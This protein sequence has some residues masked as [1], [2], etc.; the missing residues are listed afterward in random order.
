MILQKFD[1]IRFSLSTQIAI[2]FGVLTFVI[3]VGFSVLVT[4][5]L[6]TAVLSQKSNELIENSQRI[7]E[8]LKKNENYSQM[9]SMID[10][11]GSNTGVAYQQF[12]DSFDLVDR[13]TRQAGLPYYVSYAVY[14]MTDKNPVYLGTNDPF[15]PLL[16]PA[17][18]TEP[19][20]HYERNYYSDGDLNILCMTISAGIMYIQ[21]SVNMEGDSVDK[22]LLKLPIIVLFLSFPLM[23]ISFFTAKYLAARMLRPVAEITR[24][25]N[26]IS[27]SNLDR[28]IPE[29]N[30]KDEIHS[31][32]RTFNCLFMRLQ[33]DFDRERRFTSDVSHELR[34]PLAVLSG[35]LDVLRRWG[36]N[37]PVVLTESLETLY[38]ET[39]LMHALVE[40]LLLLS[41]S[42]RKEPAE[43]LFIKLYPLLKKIIDDMMIVTPDVQFE[44]NCRADERLFTNP[45]ILIQ[46]LRII[47]S[48]SISYS[49][50]PAR[51]IFTYRPDTRELITKDFGYGIEEKDLPHIFERLYRADESRNHKT[52]GSGLGLAI[53]QTLAGNIGAT[54]RA[55]SKGLN[56]G[57]SII[58]TFDIPPQ[59]HYRQIRHRRI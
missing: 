11:L 58:L 8:E 31:L 19:V 1:R 29:S 13:I 41:R 32:A 50:A 20:R 39:Q 37:D 55:E 54:I 25:A 48:N 44:L 45:E 7:V 6:R 2:A 9:L 46:I 38:R 12:Q 24:T 47:V 5:F 57:T 28:R 23:I 49:K 22:L 33:T 40:N 34:T 27:A 42:E 30:A 21:T 36:R 4:T 26:E 3:V 18:L 17:D 53:A 16:A 51:I 10:E 52:G 14:Y 35:H 56:C 59:I 43:K 15:L